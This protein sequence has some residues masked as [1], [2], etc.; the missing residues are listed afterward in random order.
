MSFMVGRAAIKTGNKTASNSDK[1]DETKNEAS[2]VNQENKSHVSS[3]KNEVQRATGVE[4]FSATA[5][6]EQESEDKKK[7]EKQTAAATETDKAASASLDQVL[8]AKLRKGQDV[9]A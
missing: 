7:I 1:V 6:G 9:Q 8:M 3:L 4:G 5:D 2:H